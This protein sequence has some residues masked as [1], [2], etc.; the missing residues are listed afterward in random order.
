MSYLSYILELW[1]Q[2][3]LTQDKQPFI[4]TPYDI[5][6]SYIRKGS[7][8]RQTLCGPRSAWYCWPDYGSFLKPWW[9]LETL[10][11]WC[12]RSWSMWLR[13]LCSQGTGRPLCCKLRVLCR[14][15]NKEKEM[16]EVSLDSVCS[17][18]S[19]LWQ[20]DRVTLFHTWCWDCLSETW[21]ETAWSR[22]RLAAASRWASWAD[23]ARRMNLPLENNM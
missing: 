16:T 3:Q 23:S 21:A 19:T 1:A 15:M 18:N 7:T 10:S 14:G 2:K 11:G 12:G 8:C 22:L 9:S 4:K 20:S 5:I 6:Q 17:P 13:P